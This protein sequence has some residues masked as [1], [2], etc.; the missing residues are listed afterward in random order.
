MHGVK[1]LTA[2]CP[3]GLLG[4]G[5]WPQLVCCAYLL[6][7]SDYFRWGRTSGF[8]MKSKSSLCTEK[9]GDEARES[10]AFGGRLWVCDREGEVLEYSGDWCLFKIQDGL[11]YT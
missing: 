10:S 5:C 2:R 8:W 1:T 6:T 11:Q 4:F 3:G 9:Q 7:L